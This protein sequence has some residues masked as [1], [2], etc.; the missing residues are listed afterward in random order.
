[1][2]LG[3]IGS[4]ISDQNNRKPFK[5]TDGELCADHGPCGHHAT[6]DVDVGLS[7]P[8]IQNAS[9]CL[10][11]LLSESFPSVHQSIQ[12]TFACPLAAYIGRCADVQSMHKMSYRAILQ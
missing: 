2:L 6:K 9:I 3:Y 4:Q 10:R 11:T 8:S 1:M 7:P 12:L 5:E